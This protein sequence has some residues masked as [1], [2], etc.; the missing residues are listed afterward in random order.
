MFLIDRMQAPQVI[1]ALPLE[2]DVQEL[3]AAFRIAPALKQRAAARLNVT[4][5][6]AWQCPREVHQGAHHGD[7]DIVRDQQ[8]PAGVGQLVSCSGNTLSGV[9]QHVIVHTDRGGQYCSANYQALLKRHNLCGNMSAKGCCY[10]IA[11]AESFIHS[12]KV[13]C[14]YGEPA[15][16]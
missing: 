4:S 5:R 15:G 13:E 8:Q 10:D 2:I 1:K 14:I 11:C 6:V 9:L 7:I 16:K 12:M 3:F